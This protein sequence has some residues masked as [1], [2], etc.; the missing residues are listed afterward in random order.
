[1]FGG[2]WREAPFGRNPHRCRGAVAALA[3]V[4]VAALFSSVALAPASGQ[5]QPPASRLGAQSGEQCYSGEQMAVCHRN[6]VQCST[7]LDRFGSERNTARTELDRMR[8]QTCAADAE[9]QWKSIVTRAVAQRLSGLVREPSGEDCQYFKYVVQA[10]GR[11]SFEGLMPERERA[12][13]NAAKGELERTL[14]GIEIVDQGMRLLQGRC[15]HSL[16]DLPGYVFPD[17]TDRRIEQLDARMLARLPPETDCPKLVAAIERLPTELRQRA[18]QGVWVV[19]NGLAGLCRRAR[20]SAGGW[21]T[22]FATHDPGLV[23]QRED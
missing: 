22:T 1:M 3:S 14:P 10:P 9:P 6:L 20:D 17:T 12:Q 11:V 21:E 7:V 15:P 16:P 5:T 4:A 8:R 18:Q 23:P 19:R 13:V 2:L